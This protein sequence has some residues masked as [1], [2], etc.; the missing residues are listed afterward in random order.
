MFEP[1]TGGS[2]VVFDA[3]FHL[4]GPFGAGQAGD[5]MQC[6]VDAGADARRG[7]DVPVIDEAVAGP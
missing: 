3:P 1:Y 7:D 4:S 6:H 5:E 2:G